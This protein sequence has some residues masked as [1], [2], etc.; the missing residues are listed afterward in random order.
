MADE[1]IIHEHGDGGSG[2]MMFLAF[3]VVL[4]VAGLLLWRFLPVGGRNKD[5]DVNVSGNLPGGS[6]QQQGY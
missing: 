5:I 3:I 1:H 6:S 2:A 4:V